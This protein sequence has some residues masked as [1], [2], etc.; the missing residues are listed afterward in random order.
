MSIFCKNPKNFGTIAKNPAILSHKS[1]EGCGTMAKGQKAAPR[2]TWSDARKK[3]QVQWQKENRMKCAADVPREV[4]ETFRAWC[5]SQNKTV[6]AV[7]AD[8]IYSIVGREPDAT[9]PEKTRSTENQAGADAENPSSDAQ[10]E[11]D[12]PDTVDK[13]PQ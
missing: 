7:L 4:G 9:P 12:T 11:N 5:K 13:N 3:T 2:E 1:R 8:Y 6:S 10:Q